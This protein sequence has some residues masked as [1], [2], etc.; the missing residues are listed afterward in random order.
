MIDVQCNGTG[1][2]LIELEEYKEGKK[3]AY[4]HHAF[5]GKMKIFRQVQLIMV[6]CIDIIIYPDKNHEVFPLGLV[7]VVYQI[8]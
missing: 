6:F 8:P 4:L 3:D 5:K 2:W 7:H 1:K